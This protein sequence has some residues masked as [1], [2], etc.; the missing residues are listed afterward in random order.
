MFDE[1]FG[2]AQIYVP[3]RAWYLEAPASRNG[4]GQ[5]ED[6]TRERR[7]VVDLERHLDAWFASSNKKDA[8]RVICGGPG[9][10][11]T[12]SAKIWAAKLAREGHRV[13]FGA[14]APP[15]A[16]PR[17]SRCAGGP[18]GI[19]ARSRCAAARPAGQ[20]ARASRAFLILFDG[21][22]E[23]AMQGRAGQEVAKNFVEAVEHKID[24]LNDRENRLVQV[25][26]GGR[27]IAVQSAQLLQ[28]SG[29]ACAAISR[30]GGSFRGP[31]EPPEGRR[32][33]LRPLVAAVR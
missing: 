32:L 31:R 1:T 7:R 23:L 28:P 17:A 10:G 15:G 16:A 14:P 33:C 27:D 3:L 21:L 8:I 6:A 2:L 19:S 24:L 25:A 22:D 13:L 18:M 20:I 29:A 9:S 12:S 26:F 11:K 5:T 30:C 4:G